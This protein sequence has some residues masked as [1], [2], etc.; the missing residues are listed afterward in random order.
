L[1]AKRLILPQNMAGFDWSKMHLPKSICQ[2]AMSANL[3]N[4]DL[5]CTLNKAVYDL[6]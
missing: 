1:H 3:P 6:L 4:L 5:V 2:Q